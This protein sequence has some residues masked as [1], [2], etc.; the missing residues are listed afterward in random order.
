MNVT[1]EKMEAR[2]KEMKAEMKANNETFEVLRGTLVA[3]IN[4]H[5]ARTQAN[6]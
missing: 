6:Q 3:Q 5:E 2:L 4:I 1:Q